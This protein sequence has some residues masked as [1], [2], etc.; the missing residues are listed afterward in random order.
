MRISTC[1]APSSP[2]Q[3]PRGNL[4]YFQLEH[5]GPIF[6]PGSINVYWI[7][8]RWNPGLVSSGQEKLRDTVITL[9]RT[10]VTAALNVHTLNWKQSRESKC[11][12]FPQSFHPHCW[13]KAADQLANVMHISSTRTLQQAVGWLRLFIY[14]IS[15]VS[16]RLRHI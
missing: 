2:D 12:L 13:H 11:I 3:A 16:T 14:I 15:T 9:Q 10:Q 6:T 4:S 8:S 5:C 7:C 1:G